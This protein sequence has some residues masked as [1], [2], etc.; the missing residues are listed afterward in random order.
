MH[1]YN[2]TDQKSV[3]CNIPAYEYIPRIKWANASQLAI[4]T[5]NR[6]QNHLQFY[7]ADADNGTTTKIHEEKSDTYVEVVNDWYFLPKESMVITSE[8]SGFNHLWRVDYGKNTAKA[9]TSGDWDITNF[10]G[11][12]TKTGLAYFQAAKVV[13]M[14][15]EIYS[16][17]L[18]SGKMYNL[19][20]KAGWNDADFSDNFA[21]FINNY[22]NANTPH[23]TTLNNAKGKQLVT[24]EDNAGLG[25]ELTKYDIGQKEFFQFTT[26]QGTQLNAWMIKPH[27]FDSTKTYPVFI[28]IYGGPGSQTVKDQWDY[29]LMWHHMLAQQGYIVM[30]VDNRGTGARGAEFK[31]CTYQQLGKL[32]VEDYIETAKYLQNQKYVD[33]NRIGIWGWS[34]GGYMSTLAISKGA[35]YFK[36]AIAVAPVTTWRYYDN[37]YTERYMR[38]PQENASGY[39]DNSPINHVEKIKGNYL[40]VHGTADD[41]VHFQNTAELVTALMNADIQYDFYIY[42]DKNHSIYGGN[43]RKHLFT[44]FTNFLLE[45]L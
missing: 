7:L 9:I 28:T 14:Q 31:K 18:K 39:D 40:L 6:L 24:L 32:E 1:I 2:V 45:N 20:T 35:D 8:S 16:V 3:N 38:T 44:K 37:I 5:L 19:A 29:N 34:Y 22:T 42:T 30:S 25:E 12:N 27:N 10:Y 21:Y 13:P 43:A 33:P 15:R 4:Q 11:M 36:T 26:E 23:V 17:N 41:N